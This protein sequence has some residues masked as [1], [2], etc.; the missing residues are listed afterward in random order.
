MMDG[1]E[2]NMTVHKWEKV[3]R[4]S[5]GFGI[6]G[7]RVKMENWHVMEKYE[8]NMTMSINGKGF[9]ARDPENSCA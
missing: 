3:L 7:F 4:P 6:L 1:D 2:R 9:V 5:L 8:R